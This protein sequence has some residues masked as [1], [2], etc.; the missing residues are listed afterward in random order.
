MLQPLVLSAHSCAVLFSRNGGVTD[1]F[2]C[3]LAV[4]MCCVCRCIMRILTIVFVFA[5]I[6]VFMHVCLFVSV[7]VYACMCFVW[8]YVCD[9]AR[10]NSL[11]FTALNEITGV[12]SHTCVCDM[13][14]NVF[15]HVG[16]MVAW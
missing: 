13:E 10:P 15:D 16:H 12:I 8:D 14:P 4:H 5:I 7:S 3:P 6:Y 2:W 9:C 1:I 11:L